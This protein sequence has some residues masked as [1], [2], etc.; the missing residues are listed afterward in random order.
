MRFDGGTRLDWPDWAKGIGIVLVVVGH[1]WRGLY[2]AGIHIDPETY[3]VV[4]TLIYNFHMPLFFFVAGL[5]F[6]AQLQRAGLG[7]FLWSR[8]TGLLWPLAVWTWI[9]FAAKAAI[10]HLANNPVPW[11]DFPVVPLPPREQFWF[12]WALFLVQAVCALFWR[13]VY[14]PPTLLLTLAGAVL[15]Y[16]LRP[17]VAGHAIWLVGAYDYAPFLVLGALYAC[18]APAPTAREPWLIWAGVFVVGEA[19]ALLLAGQGAMYHLLTETL[20]VL[21]CVRLLDTAAGHWRGL[22][23]AATAYLG[24]ASLT[25][26]VGHV[27]FA[28]SLRILLLKVGIHGLA[29]HLLGGVL[30]GVL[31]PLAMAL[32]LR[33]VGLARAL[34]LR[35][36]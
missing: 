7:P 2:N 26:Y 11:S 19:L 35:Y 6:T 8:V 22:T 27:F 24:R 18:L 14:R 1:V 25:I 5:F 23:A 10:G 36:P 4:D 9:F 12:F 33:R 30:I 16:H 31:A 29:P 15:L 34:G 32:A 20:A 17:G 21:G 3:R 13:W 28:A